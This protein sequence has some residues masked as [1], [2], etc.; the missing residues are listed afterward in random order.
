VTSKAVQVQHA[1]GLT[2]KK[3]M[4]Q[5]RFAVGYTPLLRQLAAVVLV[6][7]QLAPDPD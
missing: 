6:Q 3:V 4:T 7:Y 5:L 1:G 2:V